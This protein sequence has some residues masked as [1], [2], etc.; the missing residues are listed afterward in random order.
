MK[1]FEEILRLMD[2]I[3]SADPQYLSYIKC[4]GVCIAVLR[5][6]CSS[7]KFRQQTINRFIN[8]FYRVPKVYAQEISQARES[9]SF[10]LKELTGL[11]G[12]I[13]LDSKSLLIL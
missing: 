8:F 4:L 3:N 5:R 12:M 11:F 7:H 1:S 13:C 10:L 2:T 6:F 9:H